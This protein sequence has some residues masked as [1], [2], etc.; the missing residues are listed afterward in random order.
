MKRL[1][2]FPKVS[3]YSG[4]PGLR[5][6]QSGFHS[7]APDPVSGIAI[8]SKIGVR[9][10]GKGA[11]KP[12][13][14]EV[15]CWVLVMEEPMKLVFLVHSIVTFSNEAKSTHTGSTKIS[16]CPKGIKLYEKP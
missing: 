6:T 12:R 16:Y 5:A 1:S 9:P 3:E 7:L 8:Q 13:I 14:L 11:E 10:R 4:E 2:H 15:L